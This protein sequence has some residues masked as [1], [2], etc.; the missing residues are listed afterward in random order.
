MVQRRTLRFV[1]SCLVALALAPGG[2]APARASDMQGTLSVIGME[3]ATGAIGVAVVSHAPA[4]GAEVPWVQA[5]MGAVATQ[6]DVNTD[7]GPN[8]LALLREGM[9]PQA[10][11]DTLYK[12]DPGYLRRQIGVLDRRGRPGGFTGLELT[13]FSGGVI[14]TMVA[15]Q[16]NALA[17]SDVLFAVHDSFVVWTDLALPE[18]LLASIRVG[19]GAASR[20]LRSAALLV[21]RVD[22]ERP[23]AASRWI[24]LRVDDHPDP[25]VELERLYRI[26]AASR[27]VESYLHFAAL[28]T[29]AGRGDFA[30]NERTRAEALVAAA[31]ADS[32]LPPAA[33]NA[34]AWGLAQQGTWLDR[35]EIAARRAQAGEPANPEYLDTIAELRARQGD[36]PGALGEAKK[37]LALAPGD[38]YFRERVLAF[39]GT[40]E[41]ATPPPDVHPNQ[42][43]RAKQLGK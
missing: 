1:L 29:R 18:R 37:A 30:A 10:L 11:C 31:L 27:L 22:P 14:D 6:G 15:V 2:V 39:G 41:E 9:D 16:G 32:T 26:H 35:A 25:L 40:K 13:N 34:M 42:K 21:G 4:C 8:A 12:R 23:A 19:A 33:L 43:A 24:Y 28:G 36:L 3:R 7:W 5:G 20:P 17:R 38:E